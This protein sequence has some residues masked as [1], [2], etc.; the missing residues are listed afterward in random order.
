MSQIQVILADDHG[1]IRQGIR[2]ILE[3][4][5]CIN[6]IDE[7]SNGE[8]L[9]RKIKNGLRPD[10]VLMDIQM[11]HM[12]GVDATRRLFDLLPEVAVVC[13]T[14]LD[15]DEQ[16][17]QMFDAGASGFLLKDTTRQNLVETI[18][19]AADNKTFYD[20]NMM[21]RIRKY[22]RHLQTKNH[23]INQMTT[24]DDALT[25]RELDVMRELLDAKSNKEIAQKLCISERTVQTHLSNI[26]HKMNV[27]SRTEA[28]M[29]ALNLGL[30]NPEKE[31]AAKY[32]QEVGL[33]SH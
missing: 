20:A 29:R 11:P 21:K 12:S 13:L 3:E 25:R 28:A 22:Q 17:A 30:I 1:L 19:L 10:V 32:L 7:A 27:G 14:S 9:L 2:K 26:F 31:Q 18:K 15:E 23:A 6:V 24:G 4:E 33:R 8:D 16:L 5:Q